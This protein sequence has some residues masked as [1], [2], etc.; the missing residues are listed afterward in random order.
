MSGDR[1]FQQIDLDDEELV[2]EARD[3]LI[4]DLRKMVLDWNERD[5]AAVE[6]A[7]ELEKKLEDLEDG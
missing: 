5:D 2:R 1:T 3:V 6:C 4:R 7:L